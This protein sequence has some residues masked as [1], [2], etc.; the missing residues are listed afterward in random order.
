M[1]VIVR[2]GAAAHARHLVVNADD[3]GLSVLVNDGIEEAVLAGV[4]TSA[5]LM[6][7]TPGFDDAVRRAHALGPRLGVGLHLNL[8]TGA[9][10]APAA[11]VPS[12][13][14]GAG[15]FLSLARLIRRA[16]AGKVRPEEVRREA[17]AQFARL[18]AAGIVP[19]HADSHRHVHAFGAMRGALA[20]AAAAASVRAVRR[21]LEPLWAR[22]TGAAGVVKRALLAAA[23]AAPARGPRPVP[24]TVSFRGIALL[25][26]PRFE[27]DLVALLD[28]LPEGRTEL[29]VHPGRNDPSVAAWDPYIA[30]R[31]V[32]LAALLSSPV[33][34]RLA[35]GDLVLTRFGAD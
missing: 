30:E 23:W 12:L 28:A 6:V 9:S 24:G 25:G 32:E 35:R 18:R 26:V 17:D 21:P 5:S 22:P 14:D 33:R 10:V 1:S 19:T 13:L 8:T 27:A 3:L 2:R 7:N 4:V 11:A 29:M 15:R 34:E 16:L 20:A 31:A